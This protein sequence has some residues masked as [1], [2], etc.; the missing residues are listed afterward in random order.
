MCLCVLGLL[1]P[2]CLLGVESLAS[3][4][5]PSSRC[6]WKSRSSS[7]PGGSPQ[8]RPLHSQPWLQHGSSN[9]QRRQPAAAGAAQR[10]KSC[11]YRC[12]W[13]ACFP[14]HHRELEE[15]LDQGEMWA[16]ANADTASSSER[17]QVCEPPTA[18]REP[19][20]VKEGSAVT[21]VG[22]AATGS[23]C[24]GTAWLGLMAAAA[25]VAAVNNS[26]SSSLGC[27]HCLAPWCWVQVV[28]LS[29]CAAAAPGGSV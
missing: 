12:W 15:W 10:V 1:L 8:Q 27:L 16:H 11:C 25:A 24:V 29:P 18:G 7:P 22:A 23:K 20:A 19:A 5:P 17:A 26:S 21:G 14:L 9:Q 3:R 4:S 2:P 28:S 13:P 6:Q